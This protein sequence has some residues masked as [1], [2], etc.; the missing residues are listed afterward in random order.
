MS[1]FSIYKKEL[2]E[3][4]RLQEEQDGLDEEYFDILPIRHKVHVLRHY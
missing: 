3:Q 2:E 1:F 4:A